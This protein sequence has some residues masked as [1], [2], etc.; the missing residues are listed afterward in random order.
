MLNRNFPP[1]QTYYND[2]PEALRNQCQ[3]LNADVTTC[4]MQM[5]G[6][7]NIVIAVDK[8]V[9]TNYE[10]HPTPYS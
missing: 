3:K 6:S 7:G 9:V 1:R 8:D 4:V 10:A 2:L 5:G